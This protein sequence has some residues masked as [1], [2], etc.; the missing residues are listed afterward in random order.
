MTC[1]NEFKIPKGEPSPPGA[2]ITENVKISRK[3]VS[4]I[5]RCQNII[6]PKMFI[7]SHAKYA[8]MKTSA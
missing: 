8:P 4:N 7:I 6:I 2:Q 1:T 3:F 5:I